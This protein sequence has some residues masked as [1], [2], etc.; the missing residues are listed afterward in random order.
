MS[1]VYV[2]RGVSIS[3]ECQSLGSQYCEMEEFSAQPCTDRP[4]MDRVEGPAGEVD[5]GWS[6]RGP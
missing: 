3:M 4:H 1:G 5:S 6:L 2:G